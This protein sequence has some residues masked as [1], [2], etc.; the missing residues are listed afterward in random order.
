[1]D[2]TT[3]SGPIVEFKTQAEQN[4]TTQ[5]VK[6]N[7]EVKYKIPEYGSYLQFVFKY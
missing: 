6:G 2:V 1:L 7:L 3:K 5:N 4:L